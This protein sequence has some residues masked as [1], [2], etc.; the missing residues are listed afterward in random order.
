LTPP[1][2]Y[3]PSPKGAAPADDNQHSE[4]YCPLKAKAEQATAAARANTTLL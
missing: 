3:T 1:P 4:S 2:A